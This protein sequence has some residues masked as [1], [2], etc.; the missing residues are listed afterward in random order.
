MINN[1]R[2]VLENKSSVLYVLNGNA[3]LDEVLLIL[4]IQWVSLYT[5]QI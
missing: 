4:L 3:Q 2:F 5:G 1:H